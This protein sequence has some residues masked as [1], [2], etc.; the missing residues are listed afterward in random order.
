MTQ[1]RN[2][3][4]QIIG[5]AIGEA[6]MCWSNTPTGTFDSDEAFNICKRVV[7]EIQ[8]EIGMG[9]T[10]YTQIMT[11]NAT[12]R[13]E[14]KLLRK[15]MKDMDGEVFPHRA[16]KRELAESEVRVHL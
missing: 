12:L 11:E 5:T 4:D 10:R 6:S 14:L 2:K 9:L 3:L 13:S 7:D 16:I 1:I 8:A 15:F